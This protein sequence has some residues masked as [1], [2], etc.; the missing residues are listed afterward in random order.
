M[1]GCFGELSS[2]AEDEGAA[3]GAITTTSKTDCKAACE[4]SPSCKSVS[5]CPQW[6]G[7]W[8]KNRVLTGSESQRSAGACQ[9]L[10][11]KS[12]T[13]TPNVPEVASGGE[14]KVVSYNLYWWN[15]F[16]QN[17]WKGQHVT[18]NIKNNLQPDVMG[19]QE[20]DNPG[21]IQ[22][23]TGYVAASEF[24]GAQGV[25]VKP[26]IFR[27]GDRGKLDIQATGKWGPRYVTWVQLTHTSGRTFWHFNTHWCVHS[28]NGQTCDANK[29]Y[30][31]AKNMLAVIQEKAR[32]APSIITGDFNAGMS[33][34]GPQ[35]FLKNGFSLVE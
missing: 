11:K 26:G 1:G 18:D 28:G 20:C 23:R 8:M 33:E 32:G 31:G 9:T 30:T 27:V 10:F 21:L 2:L 3:V 17:P 16:G 4:A 12:C 7:C 34:Q 14:I 6:N 15:A 29:R 35:H 5:F 24:A 13:G 22:Q 19:L 25:S